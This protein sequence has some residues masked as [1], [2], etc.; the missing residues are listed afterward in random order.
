MKKKPIIALTTEHHTSNNDKSVITNYPYIDSIVCA[1]GVPILLPLTDEEVSYGDVLSFV[2]GIVFIGG[3]DILP[4]Y[5][6]EDPIKGIGEISVVRDRSELALFHQA[7]QKKIPILGICRGLQ[8]IN[9]ALGGSLYQDIDR[10][11]ENVNAHVSET[12]LEHG[13]H[14]ILLHEGGFL[15]K[16]FET[17]R[18]LVNSYH[19]QAI[20]ELA[21][22]LKVA[23]TSSDG[24]IEAIESCDEHPLIA[25]QF[26]PERMIH[27]RKE[28]RKI[29]EYFIEM[30][31]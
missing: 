20:K 12:T 6:G 8:F 23:A 21:K 2:D 1:G 24:L 18:L 26:H 14:S 15:H 29:F 3:E 10:Q 25:T 9:V 11:L 19:H 31:R 27:A 13:F 5:Y 28:I 16:L 17:D 7:Y 22:G 4:C 30:T